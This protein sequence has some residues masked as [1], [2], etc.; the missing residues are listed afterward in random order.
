[1][2]NCGLG[3]SCETPFERSMGRQSL[4]YRTLS[5]SGKFTLAQ[6][7]EEPLYPMGCCTFVLV[8][9]NVL[10]SLCGDVDY[11]LEIGLKTLPD[12]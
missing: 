5:G 9:V 8:R 1:M 10:R 2:P 6:V 12:R 7:V 4:V 3:E 11:G